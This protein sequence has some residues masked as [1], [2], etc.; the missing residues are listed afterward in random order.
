MPYAAKRTNC[1]HDGGGA[2]KTKYNV[3]MEKS[4][5]IGR[6]VGFCGRKRSGKTM[7]ANICAEECDGVVMAFADPLKGLVCRILGISDVRLKE[8]KESGEDIG[9]AQPEIMADTISRETGIPSQDI[10]TELDKHSLNTVRDYLQVIGTDIIRKYDKDWHVREAMKQIISAM[11]EGTDVFI[12]D[13]RF[14]NER[15][16]IEDNNGECFFVVRPDCDEISSHES[17]MSLSWQMFDYGHII[18]NDRDVKNLSEELVRR[19]VENTYLTVEDR[20]RCG[21]YLPPSDKDYGCDAD[22]PHVRRMASN[23]AIGEYNGYYSMNIPV[24]SCDEAQEILD[25]CWGKFIKTAPYGPYI[26]HV[27]VSDPLIIENVKR[28]ISSTE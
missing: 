9:Q 21:V 23:I 2:V 14:P 19:V 13:V 7:M 1:L 12:D 26:G 27:Q 4:N 15:A 8:L 16:A 3:V 11:R 17:E 6:L 20:I 5:K 18:V 10:R 24:E 25:K 22:D 28:I